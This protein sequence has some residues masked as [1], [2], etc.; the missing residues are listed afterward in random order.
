MPCCGV[1]WKRSRRE[2]AARARGVPPVWR[3]AGRRSAR[4]EATTGMARGGGAAVA[5]EAEAREEEE[6]V[7]AAALAAAS[8][9]P[10]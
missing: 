2:T 5:A 7:R 4:W 9:R 1:G 3:G 6:E 10:C 8:R